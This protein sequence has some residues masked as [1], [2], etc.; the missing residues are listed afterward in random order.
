MTKEQIAK[1]W[2]PDNE[3]PGNEMNIALLREECS[4]DIQSAIDEAVN[5]CLNRVGEYV[6]TTMVVAEVRQELGIA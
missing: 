3:Q 6:G 2:V 5:Q 1:K 4:A